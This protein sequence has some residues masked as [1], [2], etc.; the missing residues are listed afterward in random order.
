MVAH[1]R[2]VSS[3]I[4]QGRAEERGGERPYHHPPLF[5]IK[6]VI[7]FPP[8]PSLSRYL[9]LVHSARSAMRAREMHVC[10]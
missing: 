5:C 3:L 9:H 6:H 4:L 2:R 1:I 10:V 8:L 7:P